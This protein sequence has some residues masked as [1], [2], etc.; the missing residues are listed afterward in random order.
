VLPF[1][2]G[3]AVHE[4]GAWVGGRI[5]NITAREMLI[6]ARK[7]AAKSL[8]I[9]GTSTTK[10]L[11]LCISLLSETPPKLISD[12]AQAISLL[13]VDQQHYWIGT[14][15]TLLLPSAVR[16][17]QAAYFT[18]PHLAR[19]LLDL[20]RDFGFDPLL[21]TAI[22]PAAGGAAFLST[23][24]SEMR[25]AGAPASRIFAR[26]NGM[27]IDRG[28]ARLSEALI[29]ARVGK[30]V[31]KKESLVV[32]K[33]ALRA[34]LAATYDLVIANPPYGRVSPTDL[35]TE[36]WRDVCHPGHLN[37]YALFTDLCLR[38]SKP[39][40]LLALVL[41]SSFVA[42]PLYGR[43]RTHIREK[44]EVLVLAS[45]ATRSDVF[46][47]VA[48]DVSI[49]VARTG[50]AH[51]VSRAVSFGRVTGIGPFKTSS[52]GLLP[53][54]ADSPWVWPG[55]Q[56]GIAVGGSSLAD[57]GATIRAGYFV[58]N[59]ELERMSKRRRSK[60]DLP[61]IWARN[62]RPPHFCHPK[63]KQG[64]GIDFVR[65]E[66]ESAG[67]VRTDALVMQRT[68]NSLQPRRLVAARVSPSVTA[69]WGGF[70]TENHT[71]VITAPSVK[72]LNTL[73]FL[74]NSAA[75]DARYRQLSGTASVSVTLLRGLDLPSPSALA[76]SIARF[77][78]TEKAIEH[79]YAASALEASRASA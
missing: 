67:I 26:L 66:Q 25:E 1:S 64:A 12:Y 56:R 51:R 32:V 5:K 9:V 55:K 57:F 73:R 34:K 71:I 23:L 19:V 11:N 2:A 69:R 53:S 24:A 48:Q 46:V 75:V 33:D 42:G 15:Y 39:G 6:L 20:V 62:I 58:W 17:A 22:D 3:N 7:T 10:R 60:R 4:P 14:F 30:P 35:S 37:K 74:L 76:D 40:G 18:P 27:E 41:P 72:I 13:D 21:H 44:A 65:F 54:A 50:A 77:G 38:L 61:L 70:V 43:L 16:R 8:D 47:D 29:A 45:V 78:F 52:A 36:K 31:R 63:A 79:A 49:I 28:L 68:T 59:R